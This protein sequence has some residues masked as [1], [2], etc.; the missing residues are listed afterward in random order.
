MQLLFIEPRVKNP[1]RIN[2]ALP[3]TFL[4]LYSYIKPRIKDVDFSYHSLEIDYAEGNNLS[5]EQLFNRYRPDMI[6]STA[7]SCNFNNT[8]KILE[9]FKTK[10]CITM[11]GGLFP[12]ANDRWV[13]ANYEFIDIVFRGEGERSFVEV[14]RRIKSG[15]NYDSVAGISFRCNGAVRANPDIDLIQNLDELPETLYERIPIKAYLKYDTRYYVFASRGCSYNCDFCTL[16][17][18]WQNN[19]RK[20]SIARV[21]GEIEQL[22]NTFSPS[23]IS[24]GD[25]TL[26]IDRCFFKE[27]CQEL[28]SKNFPVHFGGKTRIDLIDYASID[29]MYNAG[30]REVSFG[31]ESN[32]EHQLA[33]LN[34]KNVFSALAHI[35][36]ILDYASKLGFRINLNFILGTPGETMASL[37]KK[38]SFIIKHCFAPNIVPLLGFFTPHR[39][40][41]LYENVTIM[42]MKIIDYNY[43][44]YNHLQ[45]VCLP[46]SL[47]PDGLA[48]LKHTYNH[49][50]KETN[51]VKYNPLLER[52]VS[53]YTATDLSTSPSTR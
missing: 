36:D 33:I 51:S 52:E 29:S 19:H 6:V 27:L 23:Q 30:F 39:G 14:L 24:F 42:G 25:D 50:S 31:I 1:V 10:Q 4:S 21:V 13:L 38:A 32:D 3:M 41:R 45:P 17:A 28:S 15:E 5:L 12:S 18:H 43:D 46:S 26:S 11:L 35:D 7:V 20:C 16:T 37:E 48:L 22:V 47:G 8:L 49:I 34:K 9:Y 2:I 44:H 40:T 53:N